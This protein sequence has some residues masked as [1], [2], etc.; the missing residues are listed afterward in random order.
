MAHT[1]VRLAKQSGPPRSA[2][3]AAHEP[4]IAQCMRVA[5]PLLLGADFSGLHGGLSLRLGL[6]DAV[7]HDRRGGRRR[8]GV[9]HRALLGRGVAHD[10][11]LGGARSLRTQD[12]CG[13]GAADNQPVHLSLLR[14]DPNH[15]RERQ[16]K[17]PFVPG[18]LS[19][20]LFPHCRKITG[21]EKHPAAASSEFERNKPR[22]RHRSAAADAAL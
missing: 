10:I 6:V 22:Q 16:A 3:R 21:L 18:L 15:E 4:T 5:M 12:E 19:T 20:D 14:S 9:D 13:E 1:G 17:V 11:E 7:A 8:L 2:G